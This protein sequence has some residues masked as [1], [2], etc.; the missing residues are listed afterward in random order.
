MVVVPWLLVA[1]TV[2]LCSTPLLLLPAHHILPIRFKYERGPEAQ[3]SLLTALLLLLET[4]HHHDYHYLV[5]IRIIIRV[6]VVRG[7]VPAAC[8]LEKARVGS[9]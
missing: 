1:A 2:R 5:V 6:V 4:H 7:R 9:V 3:V 8:A